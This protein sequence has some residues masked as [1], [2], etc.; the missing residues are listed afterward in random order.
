MLATGLF[1][2]LTSGN[3]AGK[4]LPAPVVVASEAIQPQIAIDAKG[5]LYVVAIHRGNIAVSLSSDG[6]RTFSEPVVAID[7]KGRALGG[8]QRGPRIG[9]DDAGGIVVTAPVT[10]DDAE[11]RKKYPTADL[12]LVYSADGGKTW[13]RPRQVNEVSKMAPEALH[14]MV[15]APNGTA[16]VAWLDIRNQRRGQDLYYAKVDADGVGK[17]VFLAS[18]VCEC[19]AP[20]LAVDKAGNPI[21]VYREGG[22]KPSR[23]LFLIRSRDGGESFDRPVRVNHVNTLEDT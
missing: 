18:V 11:Y 9:I 5:H 2:V 6:G 3:L 16:H 13:T 8:R 23:E 14:W 20:G 15:V 4:D 1:L 12:Y 22:A 17:N 19:C 21:V 10:F 7:V